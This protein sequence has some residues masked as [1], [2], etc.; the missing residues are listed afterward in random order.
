MNA[1][2]YQT[3]HMLDQD[4]WKDP[5]GSYTKYQKSQQGT[6]QKL[7]IDLASY[8]KSSAPKKNISFQDYMQNRSLYDGNPSAIASPEPATSGSTP[9]IIKYN[10][11]GTHN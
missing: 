2:E 10:A 3:A 7:D 5:Q 9:K 6:K 8:Q 11:D 1:N 4:Y